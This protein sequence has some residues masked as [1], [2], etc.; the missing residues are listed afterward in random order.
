[1]VIDFQGP[2]NVRFARVE[3]NDVSLRR[4]NYSNV[5]VAIGGNEA[6][7]RVVPEIVSLL[8]E[9][10]KFTVWIYLLRENCGH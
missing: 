9:R 6:M 8:L 7:K 2:N 4:A 1:M 5:T 10:T 3:G